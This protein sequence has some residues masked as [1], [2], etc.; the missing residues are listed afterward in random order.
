M[1]KIILSLPNS[2]FFNKVQPHVR[3]NGLQLLRLAIPLYPPV[4]ITEHMCQPSV[5]PVAS[6]GVWMLL[7]KRSLARARME[8]QIVVSLT[9]VCVLWNIGHCFMIPLQH[10]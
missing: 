1:Y 6:V 10:Q 9:F 7:E 2:H 3:A 4:L 8:Y 5:S